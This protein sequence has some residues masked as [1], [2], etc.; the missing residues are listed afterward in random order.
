MKMLSFLAGELSNSA[1]YLTTFAN[2][3]QNEHN[4]Y[5]KSFGIPLQHSWI[6]FS[7]SKR[8]NWQVK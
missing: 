5:K 3:N 6:P 4:D 7:Y 8:V 1:A 2:V